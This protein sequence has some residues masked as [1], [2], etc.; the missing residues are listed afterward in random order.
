[1]IQGALVAAGVALALAGMRQ[2]Y[3][4]DAA[5]SAAR[6]RR[7]VGELRPVAFGTA[8]V[9][10]AELHRRGWIECDGQALHQS[11]YP[12][13]YGALSTTW[14]K[15]KEG[16]FRLPDLRRALLRRIPTDRQEERQQELLGADY[17]VGRPGAEAAKTRP[18]HAEVTYFIYAGREVGGPSPRG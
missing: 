8:S 6:S 9:N 11:D 16:D 17:V 1:M 12:E 13:L 10:V 7:I 18:E 2:V 15:A 4:S 5:D 3:G 14:G